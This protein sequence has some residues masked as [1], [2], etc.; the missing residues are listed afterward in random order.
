MKTLLLFFAALSVYG[1]NL[2]ISCPPG[3]FTASQTIACTVSLIAG[4]TPASFE[5][6][7]SL[8]GAGSTGA[9]VTQTPTPAVTA[10]GKAIYCALTLCMT[11]GGQTT[12]PDGPVTNVSIKLPAAVSN[13]NMSV[14]LVNQLG[15]TVGGTTVM[16]TANPPA[17][18]SVNGSPCDI[19]G[20]GLVNAADVTA[21]IQK[22]L[23][24][25]PTLADIDKNGVV[26]V[27]DVQI[28][29]K[30]ANGGACSAS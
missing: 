28:V 1:Q 6:G 20:D 13:G 30:A 23:T 5:A 21:A 2:G 15:A 18:V 22:R 7:I 27:V 24:A 9:L 11:V 4:G 25:P 26:N 16:I 8:T 14:A 29:I 10:L 19:T 12:I 17:S 3:P